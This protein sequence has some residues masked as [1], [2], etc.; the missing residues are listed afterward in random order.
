MVLKCQTHKFGGWYLCVEWTKNHN[1]TQKNESGLC[2]EWDPLALS[3]CLLI[4]WSKLAG[5]SF[6]FQ[7]LIA[8]I[9]HKVVDLNSGFLSFQIIFRLFTVAL[10]CDLLVLI[11]GQVEGR[12]L[13]YIM[14][15]QGWAK[16]SVQ[17]CNAFKRI[18]NY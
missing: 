6:S 7:D 17:A 1:H 5:F 9:H 14:C 11:V 8:N 13:S 12:N 3:T 18:S 4:V 15:V 16:V 2:E 10:F